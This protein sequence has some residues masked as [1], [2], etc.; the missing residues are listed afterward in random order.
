SAAV[1]PITATIAA[2]VI[3]APQSPTGAGFHIFQNNSTSLES[4]DRIVFS[5]PVSGGETTQAI[6]LSLRG[7]NTNNS[8]ISGDISD[9]AAALGLG[10]SKID[11]G[12]WTLS[13]NNTYTGVTSVSSGILNITGTSSGNGNFNLPGPGTL[14]FNASGLI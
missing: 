12:T 8:T 1:A 9:G 3:L 7:A 6:T 2:P 14:N 5:G 10:V 4:G 11:A 13:G